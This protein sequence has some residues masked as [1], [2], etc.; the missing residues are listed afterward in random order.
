MGMKLSSQR[1][2]RLATINKAGDPYVVPVSFRY[3]A[4]TDTSILAAIT[5]RAA[6][7]F[8]TRPTMSAWPLSLMMFYLPGSHAALEIRGRA[9]VFST[10]G[11]EIGPA[12]IQN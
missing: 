10:G 5:W 6:K 9:E 3:N 1:L 7:N 11:A 8:V 2:G 4:E 12:L